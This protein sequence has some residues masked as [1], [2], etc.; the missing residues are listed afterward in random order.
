MCKNRYPNHIYKNESVKKYLKVLKEEVALDGSTE[1]NPYE[2]RWKVEREALKSF[3]ANYGKL[4]QSK[5]DNKGGKLYKVLYDK[6]ISEL[7]GYNYALCVQW[8][9]IKLKPKSI[10]Y[11]RA[12]DKFTPNIRTNIEYDT[13]GFDNVQGTYDDVENY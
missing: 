7:I 10:V 6:W 8:D 1:D 4:M 12:L 9:A 13:R 5:E 2:K 11:V 3:V